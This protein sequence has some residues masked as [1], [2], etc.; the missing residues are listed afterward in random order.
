MILT[1]GGPIGSGKTTVA[2]AVAKRFG[3]R[4]ISAGVI[5]REMA[6][7]RGLSLEDFSKLAESDDSFDQSVDRRQKEL[8]KEGSAIVDGRL[9]GRFIDGDIKIWL[10]APFDLR[11]QRIAKREGVDISK[12]REDMK[13]R[14]KSEATRYK[15]IYSIDIYD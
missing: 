11:A 10:T 6:R 13:K 5:F 4:H 9:S 8:A 2:S 12:A 3:L 15:K 7:Q 14:E 1:V